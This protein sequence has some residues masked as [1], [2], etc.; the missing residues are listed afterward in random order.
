M[1]IYYTKDHEWLRVDE[2]LCVVGI[3]EYAAGQLGDITYVE[4]PEVGRSVAQGDVLCEVES[5]KAASEIFAPVSGSVIEVNLKL[6]DSPELINSS[7]EEDGWLLKLEMTASREEESLMSKE[8]YL[9]Y[10]KTL[11]S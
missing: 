6:E 9:D 2:R 11:E 1:S 7:A 4:L 5:V 10:I 8:D 3:T